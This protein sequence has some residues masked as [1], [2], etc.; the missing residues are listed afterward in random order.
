MYDTAETYL[1]AAAHNFQ[2]ALDALGAGS[3][4]TNPTMNF[5]LH[6]LQHLAKGQLEAHRELSSH[7]EELAKKMP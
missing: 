3:E 6:G 5:L 1:H 2:Q 4:Q 7:L